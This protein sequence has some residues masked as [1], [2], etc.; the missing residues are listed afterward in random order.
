MVARL[1]HDEF[2]VVCDPLLFPFVPFLLP[3]AQFYDVLDILFMRF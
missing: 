2:V 1:E 3:L